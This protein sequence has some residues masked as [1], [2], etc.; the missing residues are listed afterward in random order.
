MDGD[1]P[2]LRPLAPSDVNCRQIGVQGQVPNFEGR[3]FGY[4]ES[5]PPLD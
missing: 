1:D 5:G 4:P 3:R 2:G